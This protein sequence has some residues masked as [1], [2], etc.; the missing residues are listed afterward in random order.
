[1]WTHSTDLAQV[2]GLKGV[3]TPKH[4]FRDRSELRS[5]A[6]AVLLAKRLL[7]DP[8]LISKGQS[9]LE[10]FVATDPQQHRIYDLWSHAIRLPIMV[11]VRDLLSDDER[12]AYLRETVPV[13][14]VIPAEEVRGLLD[15]AA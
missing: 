8:G 7:D 4:D 6:R 14:T 13:F 2:A 12:G 11:L 3:P 1:M 15:R 10:R 5:Y 9:F